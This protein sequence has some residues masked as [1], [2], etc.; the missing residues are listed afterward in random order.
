MQEQPARAPQG[1]VPIDLVALASEAGWLPTQVFFFF[2]ADTALLEDFFADRSCCARIRGRM[3]AGEGSYVEP[4]VEPSVE[5]WSAANIMLYLRLYSPTPPT[6]P[7]LHCFTLL[8]LLYSALL[9]FTLLYSAAGPLGGLGP[10]Q[11]HLHPPF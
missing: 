5:P 2:V 11:H 8:T 1:A 9:C 10:L 4:S 3:A 6:S 7:A